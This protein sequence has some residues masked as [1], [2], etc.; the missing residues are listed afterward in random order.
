[1]LTVASMV[2]LGKVYGNL[3][4]DVRPTSR[5]LRARA[6]RIVQQLAE[7]DISAAKALLRQAG[8]STKT[9]VLMAAQRISRAESRRRL[10]AAAGSLRQ[11]LESTNASM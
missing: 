11:A 6:V 9:A 3:M 5:K 7:V 10:K 4:V 1:M 8:G 2:R